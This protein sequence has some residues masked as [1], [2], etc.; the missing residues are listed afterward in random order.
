MKKY[1]L[2]FMISQIVL[3]NYAF[4][5]VSDRKSNA[6]AQIESAFAYQNSTVTIVQEKQVNWNSTINVNIDN[7]WKF[8]INSKD[9]ITV[10]SVAL[11]L[12]GTTVA[13][14]TNLTK[15]STVTNYFFSDVNFSKIVS[16]IANGY[17]FIGTYKQVLGTDFV[18]YDDL[19]LKKIEIT[20]TW[21]NSNKEYNQATTNYL[22][23]MAK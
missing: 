10:T 9:P 12:D 20:I 7:Q 6:A 22:L 13:N 17:K 14:I 16:Q 4:A 8:N 5:D 2:C 19:Y 23:V 15:P 18:A 21:T 11:T 1:A 3:I